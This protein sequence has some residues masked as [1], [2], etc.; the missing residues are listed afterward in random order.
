M[1]YRRPHLLAPLA[2]VLVEQT[3]V[4]R[5]TST[6]VRLLS[7]VRVKATRISSLEVPE[8][9]ISTYYPQDSLF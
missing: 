1:S 5:Q 2:A 9:I 6:S 8:N 4:V 3:M 7:T